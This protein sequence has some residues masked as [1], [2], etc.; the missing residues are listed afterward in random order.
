MLGLQWSFPRVHSIPVG[1]GQPLL[2]LGGL[3]RQFAKHW[4]KGRLPPFP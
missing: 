3:G 1:A 4:L 2:V